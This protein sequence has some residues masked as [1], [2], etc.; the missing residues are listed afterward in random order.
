MWGQRPTAM[1]AAEPATIGGAAAAN[2]WPPGFCDDAD[3]A[4]G[5]KPGGGASVEAAH[6]LGGGCKLGGADA[7]DVAGSVPCGGTIGVP[8][9]A[10]DPGGYW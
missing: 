2:A 10:F 3:D 8:L 9:R 1:A 5:T 4:C 7:N 6:W